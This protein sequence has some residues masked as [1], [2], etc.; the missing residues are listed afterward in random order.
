MRALREMRLPPRRRVP[1]RV[2]GGFVA[3]AI[4]AACAGENL[5][6]APGTGPDDLLGPSVEI[7]A[8]VPPVNLAP[9]DSVAVIAAIT[10]SEGIT[11]VAYTSTLDAGG[12]APFTPIVVPLA[13]ITD[14]TMLRF[15]RRSGSTPGAAK[16]IVTAKDV[17]GDTG[18]DTVAVNL[19]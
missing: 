4:V 17:S 11:E 6:T 16:I 19:N 2:A 9:G 13:G 18:A 12:S 3:A 14:T 7:T 15:M 8:P 5:F 1:A 10:S